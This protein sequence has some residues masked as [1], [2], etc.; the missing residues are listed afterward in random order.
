MGLIEFKGVKPEHIH[1]LRGSAALYRLA[2]LNRQVVY[3]CE[4][5]RRF[6]AVIAAFKTYRPEARCFELP[7][8]EGHPFAF[9][10]TH[11]ATHRKRMLCLEAVREQRWDF[12]VASPKVLLE[13]FAPAEK[14]VEPR[15]HLQTGQSYDISQLSLALAEMGYTHVDMVGQ[16][17]DFTKRGGI[18]DVFDFAGETALRFDFFDDEL[19]EIRVFDPATQRSERVVKNAVLL[20]IYE[21]LIAEKE[22]QTFAKKGGALWN[23]TAAR[24]G[25]LSLVSDLRTRGRFSGFLHWTGLFFDKTYHLQQLLP[26]HTCYFFNDT[27]AAV[28][29]L[30]TFLKQLD[31]QRETAGEGDLL[32]APNEILLGSGT[33]QLL[34]FPEQASV[35]LNHELSTDHI[36]LEFTT[37]GVPRFG[38]NITRF[39]NHWRQQANRLPVIIVCRGS[40]VMSKLEDYI[41][42]EGYDVQ[43]L[44]FPL[45]Q[46]PEKGFFLTRGELDT[47]FFDPET[48]LAVVA[49][50]D[51]W[52]QHGSRTKHTPRGK[53]IFQSEFRDLKIGDY[54]VHQDHGVGRFLGL[55]EMEV[56][57]SEHE[58]M[59]LEYQGGNKLYVA[60]DRLDLVQRFSGGDNEVSLDKLGGSGWERA[61][62]RAKKAVR[63]MAEELIKLYAERRLTPGHAFGPDTEWQLEFEEA[64]E[65]EATSGQ[66]SAVDSIKDDMESNKPMDRLLVG[67]VGF[68]KTEVAMR[69]AFKAAVEGFQVAVLCPTTVLAFQ[70]FHTFRKRF[71]GFPVE[72]RWVSRF[73]P[74]REVRNTLA[75]VGEGKV[76]ILIGT[77]RIL[78]KDVQFRNL[79]CLIIDEEQRFGVAHKERLKNMRKQVDVLSMSATPIPRTLNMSLSGIRD[80]SVIETPPTNR[81]AVSTTVAPSK[82][83]LIKSAIE[84]ELSR[85]GQVFFVHNRVETM[86]SVV[87]NLQQL[88]PRAR[89]AGAHGQMEAKQIEKVMVDFMDRKI[90]ILV[91]STIIEN[92]VD[93]PNANTMIVNRADRFG[94]S[95]LYQLRGRIGRSDRPAYAYLLVPPKAKMTVLARKRLAAL[96]EF[97]DLG[98][99]FRI[100]SRDMELRGAGDL[101]GGKQAGHINSIGYDMYVKLLEEAVAEL[102]GE[103]VADRVHCLLNLKLDVGIPKTYISETNQRLHFYKRLSAA[104]QEES[105]DEILLTMEDCYGPAPPPLKGLLD[106]HRLRIWLSQH[107]INAVERDGQ[108]L[109]I[110][111][112]PTA[113]VNPDPI[114]KW[115]AEGR[116]V[117][118]SPEGTLSL[119]TFPKEPEKV[120]HQIRETVIQVV[121]E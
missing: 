29:Q 42:H 90:D 23:R 37:Q 101:L 28:E 41:G 36:D 48:P 1:G 35:Q 25:F 72:I 120:Y 53:K 105:L 79:G 61:K 11:P 38:G 82:E 21:W 33:P 16:P 20:P 78:S 85:E 99:G 3:F 32:Q 15:L 95:Q 47:G 74:T 65:H 31:L 7:G 73:T 98:A 54:V 107:Q 112:H 81:L 86:P 45:E 106:E 80:I 103:K 110:R 96:E 50:H 19:E 67:D 55:V 63:E 39:F 5:P 113:N 109:R 108:K 121:T 84:F 111:F 66:K 115:I 26:E 40:A 2:A 13:C 6:P 51:I 43:T 44:N 87:A 117:A 71:E 116:G 97:S 92:G 118:L 100:A 8:L 17:G 30:E 89:I 34:H 46:V 68:G 12:I 18:L 77:H 104:D 64:F 58:M 102:K 22:Q 52:P 57:G 119:P 91:A 27:D 14:L 24:D 114:L 4:D 70:H 9:T 94:M 59:A 76:N 75:M 60:M 49:E 10:P 69:M 83:G 88:V 62:S 56:G 93:I